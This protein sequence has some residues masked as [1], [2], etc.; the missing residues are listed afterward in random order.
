[1]VNPYIVTALVIAIILSVVFTVLFTF[2]FTTQKAKTDSALDFEWKHVNKIVEYD[3]TGYTDLEISC[4][5]GKNIH[6]SSVKYQSYLPLA[7]NDTNWD[8]TDYKDV[9]W[10]SYG[11]V[12]NYPHGITSVGQC[13]FPQN[14]TKRFY[15]KCKDKKEG[16]CTINLRRN[17]NGEF[18]DGD[19]QPDEDF[20]CSTDSA[21]VGTQ[22][23]KY[24]LHVS[25][26]CIND[27]KRAEIE[28][29]VRK[30][31]GAASEEE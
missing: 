10:V 1:M 6:V 13:D 16:T 17:G 24:S 26:A 20:V 7:G 15:D 18:G 19:V 31:I 27:E 14:H 8:S 21:C 28:A 12:R 22:S 23:C 9:W 2:E 29:N 30:T 5:V 11:D 3:A 4:P 25:Y